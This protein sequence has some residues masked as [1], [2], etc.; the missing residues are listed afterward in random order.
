MPAQPTLESHHRPTSLASRAHRSTVAPTL[1]LTIYLILLGWLILW[2]FEIPWVG[3]GAL[4][5]I[6]LIPFVASGHA[7][8][9]SSGEVLANVA[10]FVPFGFLLGLRAPSW[11]W[12]H[13]LLAGAVISA[14][15]E[16]LQYVLAI[17]ATDVTDVITNSAGAGIGF[18]IILTLHRLFGQRSQKVALWIS[19]V[20]TTVAIL[21]SLAFLVSPIHFSQH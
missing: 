14:F 7:A 1:F 9:S 16:A 17:G 10:F 19:A 2:K 6:K 18:A 21:A 11:R 4:R 13:I 5:S 8:A 15:F 3:S 12:W 20:C